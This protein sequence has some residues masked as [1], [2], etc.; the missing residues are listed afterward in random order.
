MSSRQIR[1]GFQ[2]ASADKDADNDD[3]PA[4]SHGLIGEIESVDRAVYR[5]VAGTPT[6]RLDVIMRRLSQAANYSRISMAESAVLVVAG[7]SRG[8]RAAGAGLASIAVTSAVVNLVAKPLGRRERPDREGADVP[9]ARR[10]KM[11]GSRSFPSGHAASAFAFASAAGSELPAA[12]IPLHA[13]AALVAYSRVHT[14]VH[15]PIDVIVGGVIGSAVADVVGA[16]ISH[17]VG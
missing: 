15:Y 13:V 7:G 17:R 1:G 5:A 14:G 12:S 10:V 16:A 8:R 2:L 3:G 9:D 6:P 11:P 4:T